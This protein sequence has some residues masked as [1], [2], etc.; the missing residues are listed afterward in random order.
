MLPFYGRTEGMD[1]FEH[2]A[3]NVIA[4]NK[5]KSP[6]SMKVT[7]LD[8]QLISLELSM[9]AVPIISWCALFSAQQLLSWLLCERCP[10][11]VAVTGQP[12]VDHQLRGDGWLSSGRLKR[13]SSSPSLRL[14]FT[15]CT[16]RTSTWLNTYEE[17]TLVERTGAHVWHSKLITHLWISIPFCL[18][19]WLYIH[20]KRFGRDSFHSPRT[21]KKNSRSGTTRFMSELREFLHAGNPFTCYFKTQICQISFL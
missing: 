3:V 21:K 2:P 6:F 7:L 12:A 4:A 8:A 11:W 16:L 14:R 17:T 15:P 9:G 19:G 10:V 1:C 18:L 13:N 5:R 20:L